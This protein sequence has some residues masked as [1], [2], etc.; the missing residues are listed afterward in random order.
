MDFGSIA[1]AP[2]GGALFSR[3]KLDASAHELRLNQV[4][5][6]FNGDEPD[7]DRV[8]NAIANEQEGWRH[9]AAIRRWACRLIGSASRS[10]NACS[11]AS[12][13]I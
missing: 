3:V 10:T 8:D 5:R 4:E 7:V 12:N 13:D 2:S 11:P 1:N 6:A 9:E